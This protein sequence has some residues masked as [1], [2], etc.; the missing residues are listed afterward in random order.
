MK[1]KMSIAGGLTAVCLSTWMLPANAQEI[2]D[3]PVTQAENGEQAETETQ[4]ETEEQAETGEQEQPVETTAA[5]VH[6]SDVTGMNEDSAVSLLNENAAAASIFLDIIK[7]YEYTGEDNE[8]IVIAQDKVGELENLSQVTITISLGQEPQEF[9]A[10]STDNGIDLGSFGLA[11]YQSAAN[12]TTKYKLGIDWDS[13]PYSYEYN[14]DNS[15][16]VWKWGMWV[17]GQC[18]IL[19][20][21]E[22]NTDV[23]HK[24]QLYCDG[25]YVYY[26]V[27][28]CTDY[29]AK[30]NGQD[31]QF[32]IDGQMAAYTLTF[33]DGRSITGNT[34]NLAPGTY[35]L[36]VR[37]RNSALSYQVADGTLA[38][39]TKYDNDYNAE[40]EM[41]VPLAS[42]K[43]QNPDI[44]IENI[45]SIE[46]FNPNLMYR[47]ITAAGASTF[48]LQSAGAAL[49]VVPLSTLLLGRKTKKSKTMSQR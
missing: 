10:Q 39:M 1:W 26:H 43:E 32:Y 19:P 9:L 16:S 37:H 2:V 6:I 44:D 7:N 30:V 48:P 40:I 18:I 17:N 25:T 24:M 38:Y 11:A 4:A 12:H 20:Q 34:G 49:L 47:R 14:W 36:D 13:L 28:M 27:V 8:G 21:G 5:S 45:G 29:G 35:E 41:R 3:T 23:R 33:R 15:D 22:F 42:M 31:Y 46:F